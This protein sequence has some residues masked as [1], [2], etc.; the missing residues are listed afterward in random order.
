MP[1]VRDFAPKRG[2]SGEI[3]ILGKDLDAVGNPQLAFESSAGSAVSDARP[4]NPQHLKAQIP[5]L[6][7][8]T[9]ALTLRGNNFKQLLGGFT[10]GPPQV[11]LVLNCTFPDQVKSSGGDV[12]YILGNGFREGGRGDSPAVL[13]NGTASRTGATKDNSL[14]VVAS[15]PTA[16]EAGAMPGDTIEVKVTFSDQQSVIGRV[17]YTSS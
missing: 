10:V 13:F 5:S 9:Y 1:E 8:A 15:V 2:R 16:D 7:D 4:V 17:T 6:N 14:I 3:N 12:L 11:G